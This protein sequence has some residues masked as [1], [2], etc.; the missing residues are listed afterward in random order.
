MSRNKK[1]GFAALT[2]AAILILLGGCAQDGS[3]S[4]KMAAKA[5]ERFSAADTNHDGK[6][7]RD[8]AASGMPRIADHFDA[9]DT[10]GDGQ[11]SPAEIIAYVKQRRGSR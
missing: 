4:E 6:L 1:P 7:S 2:L 8:E 5:K 10:D 11:L 3:R 9:I